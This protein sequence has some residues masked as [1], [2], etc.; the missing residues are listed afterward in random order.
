MPPSVAATAPIAAAASPAATRMR[1]IAPRR[2][3]SCSTTSRSSSR[4]ARPPTSWPHFVAEGHTGAGVAGFVFAVVRGELGVAGL[5]VVRLGLRHR[6]LGLP[7]G[8]DGPDGRRDRAL[9]RPAAD[10]RVARP[11]RHARQPGDGRGLRDHARRARFLWWRVSRHDPERRRTARAYMSTIGD[12]QVGWVVLAIVGLPVGAAFAAYIVLIALE[13]AGPVRRRARARTPWHP[14]HIAERYGLLVIITLGEV[15][16]GT[17]AALNARRARRGGVDRRAALLAVAGVGLTFGCWWM[18]FA[19]PWAEPLV[20]HRERGFV[21]RLRP[22]G[23]LRRARGDGRRAARRRA[24]PRGR[25]G[26]RPPATVLSVAIPVAVYVVRSTACTRCS[27]ASATRSTS[28]CSRA[29]RR[30]WSCRSCSPRRAS[31]MAV[32]LS[33]SCCAPVVTVVGYE[34]LGHRHMA[35]ALERLWTGGVR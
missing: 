29:P 15:I 26:D 30:C 1:A 19:M 32:C 12:A 23:G 17:V 24:R 9:A 35:Q 3:W 14:H 6:R 13:L 11:R 18:Y 16:L 5:L 21:V 4:S 28:A 31:S 33:C 20:R 25:G 2:R 10:V 27:C 8:D 7:A 34:T 22:P